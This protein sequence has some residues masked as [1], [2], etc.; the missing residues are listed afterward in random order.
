MAIRRS[1]PHE[2]H[3]GPNGTSEEWPT[4]KSCCDM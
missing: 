4:S 3:G 2:A 1:G